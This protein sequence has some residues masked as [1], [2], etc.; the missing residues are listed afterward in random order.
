MHGDIRQK[1]E[2]GLAKARVQIYGGLIFAT[3]NIEGPSLEEFLGDSKWYFDLLFCRTDSG[4]EMLGPPQRFIVPANWK[5]AAEQSALRHIRTVPAAPTATRPSL[6]RPV[7]EPVP[8]MLSD[9][10]A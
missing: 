5:A 7:F 10:M 1:S 8:A 2:L 6:V 3:W 4:L 9:V